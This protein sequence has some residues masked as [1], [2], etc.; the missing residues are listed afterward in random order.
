M[1]NNFADY[2]EQAICNH[3][4]KANAHA[5]VAQ[6]TALYLAL[7]TADP[8]EAGVLTNEISG[9]AYARQAISFGAPAANGTAT[10]ISNSAQLNFP[11]ATASWGTV[12]YFAIIDS[13]SGA[14]NF[15]VT[16]P[17]TSSKTVNSGDT[18]QVPAGNFTLDID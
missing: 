8:T 5:A 14:G 6:P 2:L 3:F 9:G 10:R 12:A 18:F 13:A 7:F 15:F 17:L 4:F 1:A 16:G 11:Q